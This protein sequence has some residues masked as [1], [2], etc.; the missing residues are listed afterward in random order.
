MESQTGDRGTFQR[1]STGQTGGALH[2]AGVTSG[3]RLWHAIRRVDGSWTSFGDVEGEAG[4][5]GSFVTVSVDGL[6][7]P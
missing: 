5:R 3:G 1:V 6:H 4:D 2:V 7:V